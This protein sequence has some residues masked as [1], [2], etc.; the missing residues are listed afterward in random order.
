MKN[1]NVRPLLPTVRVDNDITYFPSSTTSLVFPA[2]FP[3]PFSSLPHPL[4]CQASEQLQS[5]LI[6]NLT[7]PHDFYA[8]GGGKM[9]GVLI[10][11]DID[12]RPGFL[13]AFSGKL[14]GQ[15]AWPGFVL[16]IFD[17]AALDQ[18][19]PDGEAELARLSKKI[20]ILIESEAYQT[21]KEKLISDQILQGAE[22][23]VLRVRLA[24]NKQKRQSQRM[25]LV[26]M[27]S[28]EKKKSLIALSFE[29]QQGKQEKKEFHK[30]W[31][32]IIQHSKENL[33]KFEAKIDALKKERAQISRQLH[34]RVFSQYF[35][36]NSLDEEGL[37]ADFFENHKPPG[38][39]G[40]CAAPKLLHYAFQ[41]KFKPIALA[42]FWWGAPPAGG[43]RHHKHYYPACRGKCRP[44]LPFMLKGLSVQS[45]PKYGSD[46]SDAQAPY[47]VYEN[48]N[49]LVV[50]KPEGLL[51]VP[52]KE[53]EDS[54]F[55]RMKQR[56]PKATGPLLVHRLDLDTSGLLLVAKNEFTH[57]A[58][59]QQFVRRIVKK[60]Y[61]ALLSKNIALDLNKS[62]G[63]IE[64][65]LRVDYDDRPRQLVCRAQGK[66]ARTHWE[67][68]SC[69]GKKTRLYFYP[70]TGRTHQLR[71]H[72]SHHEGLNAPI[73]G[74]RLYGT[75]S[76]RLYLHAERLSFFNPED[77]VLIDVVAS[78]PF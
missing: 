12:G 21:L 30:H 14:A 68:I 45:A 75:A 43:V 6:N 42:E 59:Q 50:N 62:S 78:A 4:A 66:F 28:L 67:I 39:A 16:P 32:E 44:I 35:L 77:K 33:Q 5:L 22:Y 61:V 13:S 23:E 27:S 60:R 41:H 24:K 36:K 47:T 15:W 48:E 31:V 74:D 70:H 54:V 37:I 17:E 65:P 58:L 25:G 40:D 57:K 11:K 7:I 18:F 49:L 64:L 52:G 38:G 20:T 51:S 72:A 56:Y 9:F 19:L 8:P 29:S 63:T 1:N 76:N 2:E 55:T 46:F 69:D 26:S 34:R 53:V 73:V 10:V 71:V 3:S